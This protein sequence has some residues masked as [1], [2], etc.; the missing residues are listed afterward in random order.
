MHERKYNWPVNQLGEGGARIWTKVLESKAHNV[1]LQSI[2]QMSVVVAIGDTFRPPG[3]LEKFICSGFR[4]LNRNETF[5]II[6]GAN[7]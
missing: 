1:Q 5:L 7:L 2:R 4:S 3:D 6:F